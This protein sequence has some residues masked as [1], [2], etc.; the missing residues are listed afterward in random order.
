ND[1]QYLIKWKDYEED[2][3]TWEFV[4]NI[5]DKELINTYWDSKY[6]NGMSF[7]QMKRLIDEGEMFS[8]PSSTG[9]RNKTRSRGLRPPGHDI[10]QFYDPDWDPCID[11]VVSMFRDPSDDELYVVLSWKLGKLRRK[12]TIHT[13]AEVRRRCPQKIIEFFES[14]SAFKYDE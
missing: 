7:V 4:D 5:L 14:R 10:P 3:N 11:N 8:R 9:N 2:Q 6:D 12:H 13:M 1:I